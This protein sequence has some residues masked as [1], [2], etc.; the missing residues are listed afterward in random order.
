MLAIISGV[1]RWK[2]YIKGAKYLTYIITDHQSLKY[3]QKARIT[4]LR[5]AK[6]TL[7]VQ[8]ISYKITYW[9]EK[10]NIVTD[11][12]S[13]TEE[14]V[15]KLKDRLIL[16][17]LLSI[18]ERKGLLLKNYNNEKTGHSGAVKTI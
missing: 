5:Q 10:E 9:P 2:Y 8:E 14:R 12:L 15:K 4:N 3:F 11:T 7:K 18:K 13:R 1:K 17:A 6:W 16:L